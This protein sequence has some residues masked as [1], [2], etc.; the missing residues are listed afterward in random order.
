MASIPNEAKV[1]M[2]CGKKQRGLITTVFWLILSIY[3]APYIYNIIKEIVEEQQKKKHPIRWWLKQKCNL[4][5][6]K[7][8]KNESSS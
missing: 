1:C 6:W 2:Y 4:N 3:I 8:D 7:N 5:R